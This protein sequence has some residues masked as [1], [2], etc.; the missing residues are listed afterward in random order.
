MSFGSWRQTVQK[1]N[2]RYYPETLLRVYFNYC[3]ANDVRPT[4]EDM[5]D[6]IGEI[7]GN[8]QVN[9]IPSYRTIDEVFNNE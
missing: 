7:L 5:D 2:D 6:F 1:A 3:T 4:F 9:G 8:K